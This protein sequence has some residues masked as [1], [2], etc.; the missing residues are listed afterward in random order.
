MKHIIGLF[1]DRADAIRAQQDL[2][3]AGFPASD[4]RVTTETA[5]STTGAHT[6]ESFWESIKDF[7]GLEPTDVYKEAARRGGTL[8]RVQTTDERAD[9]AADIMNRFN[10]VDVDRRADE[11]RKEGW[12]STSTTTAATSAVPPATTA[13]RTPTAPLSGTAARSTTSGEQVIPVTQEELNIGKRRIEHGGVRVFTEVHETPVQKDVTLRD[14]KVHIERRPADRPAGP[15][16]FQERTI[17]AREVHEEPVINKEARVTEEVVIGKD[18]RE[19][20]EQVKDKVRRTDVKV[21]ELEDSFR[22][23][24]QKSFAGTNYTY[25]Q[26]RPAYDMGRQL[27]GEERF[28]DRDWTMV[29]PE[30]RTTVEK[31]YPGKWETFRPAVRCGYNEACRRTRT[32]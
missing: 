13:P 11:W 10:P 15:E 20:T 22:N 25:D 7:L 28:R 26:V 8:L 9:M 23:D 27:A 2:L 18:V 30:A 24:F 16:A 14:E 19:R 12:R 6:G 3:R 32:R 5:G 1:D 29:E 17:E 21:E 31:R 4:V